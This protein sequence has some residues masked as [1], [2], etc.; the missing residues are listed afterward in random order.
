MVWLGVFV[1]G[2]RVTRFRLWLESRLLVYRTSMLSLELP[3]LVNDA[4]RD[5]R[6]RT[7]SVSTPALLEENISPIGPEPSVLLRPFPSCHAY[8]ERRKQTVVTPKFATASYSL[9]RSIPICSPLSCT[10]V[11]VE[12]RS[13]ETG[14]PFC[15][16]DCFVPSYGSHPRNYIFPQS[17]YPPL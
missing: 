13:R 12:Y 15:T 3:N 6:V 4:F 11:G 9:S 10:E 5:L 8:P 1:S 2:I 7:A 16:N 14:L 17:V